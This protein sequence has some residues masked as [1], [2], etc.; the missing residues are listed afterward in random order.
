VPLAGIVS[1]AQRLPEASP[2]VIV[3]RPVQHGSQLVLI[4]T[5][6]PEEQ[7]VVEELDQRVADGRV[8]DLRRRQLRL[9]QVNPVLPEGSGIR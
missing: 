4:R 8:A 6:Y 9:R 7:P 2:P 1:P 5:E 3:V